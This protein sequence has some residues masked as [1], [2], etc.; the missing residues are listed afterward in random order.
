MSSPTN[1]DAARLDGQRALV[2]G[3]SRGIGLAIVERL[4]ELGA[5]V[6][7]VARDAERLERAIEPWRARGLPAH[8]VAADVASR[9]GRARIEQAVRERWDRLDI[10]VNNAGGNLR[11]RFDGYDDDDQRALLELNLE[12]T[13]SLCRAAY[14]LLRQAPERS[15]S[16]VADTGIQPTASVVNVASVAALTG[17]GT[18]AV[19]AAAKAG[20]A[21]LSRYLAVE[22]GADAIRVNCVA[23]WYIRTPL[24]EEVLGDPERLARVL[25]RTPLGRVGE[26]GE[27]AGVVAF[28]CS[29]AASYVSGAVI[30]V[31]GGMLADQRVM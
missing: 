18:G 30:P 14:P 6:M 25:A 7:L 16:A 22:W 17:V 15:R 24:V 10:L 21:H 9:D 31:D 12:A 4:L 3:G 20:V 23:P 1:G 29:P 11:R 2:T 13:M 19:Y 8:G 5:E 26:P 27:V 28:L